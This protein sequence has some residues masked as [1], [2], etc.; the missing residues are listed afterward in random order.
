MIDDWF[1]RLA[2][3]RDVDTFILLTPDH[4]NMGRQDF[5]TTAGSWETSKGRVCSDR[6]LVRVITKKA[7]VV[8]EPALF[9]Y[10]HGA[11]ILMPFIAQYFSNGWFKEP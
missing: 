2:E 8:C 5:S 6:H 7:G 11:G 4:N 9:N 3:M 1:R 10:E